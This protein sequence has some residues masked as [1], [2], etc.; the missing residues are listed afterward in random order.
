MICSHIINYTK[1]ITHV[2][3]RNTQII[4]NETSCKATITHREYFKHFI[5]YLLKEFR[6]E[7]YIPYNIHFIRK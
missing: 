2:H 3:K 5:V 4:L 7:Y 6:K 1:R